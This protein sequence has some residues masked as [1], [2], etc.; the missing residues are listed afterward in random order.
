MEKAQE[1][2][3]AI[4]IN[5]ADEMSRGRYS[6]TLLVTHG[7]EEFIMDFLLQ[8]PNGAHLVARVIVT[9]GHMKRIVKALAENL[10]KYEARFGEIQVDGSTPLSMQ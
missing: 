1:E 5:T 6:N 2:R 10:E 4:P 7:P 8:S 9:P 3:Q